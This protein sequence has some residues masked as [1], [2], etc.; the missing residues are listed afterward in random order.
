MNIKAMT[1]VVP[2]LFIQFRDP[3]TDALMFKDGDNEKPVGVDVYGPGS[4]QYRNAQAA[5]AT[6]NIKRGKK[7]LTGTTI[8]DNETELLARTTRRF[9]NFEYVVADKDGNDTTLPESLET[10]KKFYDDVELAHLREQ[11]VEKQGDLG[12]FTPTASNG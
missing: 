5:I 1:K 11:V 7:G 8:Q 2:T 6:A 9:V 12:N 4:T 3:A 10:Y